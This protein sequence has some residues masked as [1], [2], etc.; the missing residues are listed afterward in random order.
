M[1]KLLFALVGICSLSACAL[2]TTNLTLAVP[3]G[4]IGVLSEAPPTRVDVTAVTDQRANQ[5]RIGDKRNGYGQVMGAV[6]VTQPPPE[7]VEQALEH[8]MAANNHLI[9]GGDDQYELQTTLRNFWFDYRAGL[10]TVEMFGSIQADVTLVD[11]P[12]GESLYS[13]T[14][15]GYYSERNAGGLSTSWTRIMNAA[16]EDFATKV[17]NSEGLKD[18]LATTHEAPAEADAAETTS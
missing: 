12:S 9:G 4:R 7:I 6:G 14:F 3:Q 15:D 2:G 16:L 1:R 11:R 17:S 13:E 8:V 18:A 5:E 10:L